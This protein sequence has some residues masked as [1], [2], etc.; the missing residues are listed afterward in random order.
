M[1]LMLS[2]NLSPRYLATFVAA[3]FLAAA[4]FGPFANASPSLGGLEGDVRLSANASD[5]SNA[6]FAMD[7]RPSHAYA[8]DGRPANATLFITNSLNETIE[9]KIAIGAIT[10]GWKTDFAEGAYRVPSRS[11]VQHAV[12][13]GPAADLPEGAKGELVLHARAADGQ[14]A[15]ALLVAKVARSEPDPRPRVTMELDPYAQRAH[16]GDRVHYK[17]V[18][19]NHGREPI[20]LGFEA[21]SPERMVK[22]WMD[23]RGAR[24]APNETR[25]FAVH[26]ASPEDLRPGNHTVVVV[27]RAMDATTQAGATS[28]DAVAKARARLVIVGDAACCDKPIR[29]HPTG[30]GYRIFVPLEEGRSFDLPIRVSGHVRD[31]ML[32]LDI[33]VEGPQG[34]PTPVR[35][36]EPGIAAPNPSAD[37]SATVEA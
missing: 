31:G 24:L 2:R 30:N 34:G 18:V 1:S 14:E 13:L 23:E 16:A 19:K 36:A 35:P 26:A 7:F 17:L 21:F 3:T 10:R 4:L 25:S 8:Y 27:A 33:A 32:V 11:M 5:A 20:A 12:R 28:G 9:L 29:G 6:T 15:R 22:V 37:A